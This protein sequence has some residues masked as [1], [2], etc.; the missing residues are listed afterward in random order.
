MLQP[1]QSLYRAI[2]AHNTPER[3]F[4]LRS[5]IDVVFPHFALVASRAPP[6]FTNL[7]LFIRRKL[8]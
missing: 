5:W 3:I 1:V 2:C 4:K 8:S 7:E 6:V